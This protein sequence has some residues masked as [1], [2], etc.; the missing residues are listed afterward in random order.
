MPSS[1]YDSFSFELGASSRLQVETLNPN[2]SE[3][4]SLS[5]SM[6]YRYESPKVILH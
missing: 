5:L 2:I 6:M 4:P 3:F 1:F